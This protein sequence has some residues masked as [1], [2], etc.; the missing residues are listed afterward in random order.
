[1]D[2][3]PDSGLARGDRQ[4]MR[5]RDVECG[6]QPGFARAD[7]H[8]VY[9]GI[10]T[11]EVP[12]GQCGIVGNLKHRLPARAAHRITNVARKQGGKGSR[13]TAVATDNHRALGGFVSVD[14]SLPCHDSAYK[15][16]ASMRTA[17]FNAVGTMSNDTDMSQES[18]TQV[19]RRVLY[20]KRAFDLGLAALILIPVAPIAL[21]T[22]LAVKLTSPGP[23]LYWSDRIGRDQAIFR[24]PK[25]RSMK[26]GT[27]VVAT[28]LL[29]DGKSMLTPIGSFLRKTSLDEIPQIW[30]VLEGNMSFV[31]PRPA[32]FNQ[33]D[34]IGLREKL[35]VNALRPGVTGWA[36][37]NGRDELPIPQKVVFDREYLE[38]Q[39]LW[40][41]LVIL[42]RTAGK[43]FGDKAVSH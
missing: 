39:S 36:Q 27:P 32:L 28:H 22:A 43:L 13:D 9:H 42:V 14:A 4:L 33:Y 7:S 12:R 41:D 31:G 5:Q 38:R 37:I 1:M 11:L 18:M 21:L 6:Q 8:A 23:V 24:M 10:A 26:I 20:P 25:F 17:L 3:A 15:L 40:L 30:S 2:E 16:D 29:P 34:L 35:G 19:P